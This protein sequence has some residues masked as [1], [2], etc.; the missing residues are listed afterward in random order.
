MR[1]LLALVAAAALTFAAVGWYLDWYE[2]Y[3]S[4]TL[5]GRRRVSID[6]DSRKIGEDLQR[7]GARLQ[8][9]LDK[10]RRDDGRRS[11]SRPLEP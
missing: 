9:A 1:N 8:D 3:T 5:P 11:E 10:Q 4:P 2:I 7:G 6:I